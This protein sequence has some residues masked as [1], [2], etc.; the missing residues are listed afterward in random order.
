MRRV[1]DNIFDNYEKKSVKSAGHLIAAIACLVVIV[2]MIG[3]VF[4]LNQSMEI[5]SG[6]VPDFVAAMDEGRYTDALNL[7]RDVHDEVVAADSSSD[8]EDA[9]LTIRREQMG[10]MEEIVNTRLLAI[11]DQI[12]YE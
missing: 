6:V 12:R 2:A 10:Q 4:W 7:Y 5:E 3:V 11:E 9:V 1:E 8:E